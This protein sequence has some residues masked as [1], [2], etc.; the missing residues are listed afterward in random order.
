MKLA[1]LVPRAVAAIAA[2][3]AV[4]FLIWWLFVRPY[5]AEQAAVGAKVD[6]S[7]S[8]RTADAAGVALD[9]RVEVS[10]EHAESDAITEENDRAIHQANGAELPIGGDVDDAGRRALCLRAAYQYSAWCVALSGAAPR[11]RAS[12]GDAGSNAAV[13]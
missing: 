11:D 10:T 6:A 1:D 4:G 2:L 8:A 5:S 7:V 9:T 13:E 3:L 12:R